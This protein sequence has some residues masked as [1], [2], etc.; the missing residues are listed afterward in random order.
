MTCFEV[1]VCLA[2][3]LIVAYY[4]HHVGAV[5]VFCYLFFFVLLLVVCLVC[6]SNI[7]LSPECIEDSYFDTNTV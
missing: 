7:I 3:W 2:G 5:Y 1:S 6:F 4:W